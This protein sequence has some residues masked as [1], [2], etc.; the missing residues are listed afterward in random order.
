MKDADEQEEASVGGSGSP[1]A[2]SGS[3]GGTGRGQGAAPDPG[4]GWADPF[5]DPDYRHAPSGI[6]W[7]LEKL[8]VDDGD[9]ASGLGVRG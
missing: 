2:P 7:L 3:G 4:P 8:G 9:T 1:A 6:E 5:T